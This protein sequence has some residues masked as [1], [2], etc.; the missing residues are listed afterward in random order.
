MITL[1]HDL[2]VIHYLV[3]YLINYLINY[4]IHN[5]IQNMKCMEILFG[6][7]TTIRLFFKCSL[8]DHLL[9]LINNLMVTFLIYYFQYDND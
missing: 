1:I 9:K 6:F 5:L 3:T 4:L 7:W 8:I 2:P